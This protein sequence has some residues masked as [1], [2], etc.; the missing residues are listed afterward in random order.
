MC[1]S[2]RALSS[3]AGFL[4]IHLLLPEDSRV[5]LL[6]TSDICIYHTYVPLKLICITLP[7]RYYNE[8]MASSYTHQVLTLRMV[9]ELG[10]V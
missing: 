3:S 10:A 2:Q 4:C 8:N 5:S 7:S 1:H 9:F 6:R